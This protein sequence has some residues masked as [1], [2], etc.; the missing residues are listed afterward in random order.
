MGVKIVNFLLQSTGVGLQLS[1]SHTPSQSEGDLLSDWFSG[2]CNSSKIGAIDEELISRFNA[3][4]DR[5]PQKIEA[6]DYVCS[7]KIMKS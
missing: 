4:T 1:I 7:L 2:L 5:K 3:L 6:I